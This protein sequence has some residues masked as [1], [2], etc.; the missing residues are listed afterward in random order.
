[1]ILKTSNVVTVL[2]RL[3]LTRLLFLGK[4]YDF[5]LVPFF[6]HYCLPSSKEWLFKTSDCRGY[7][8]RYQSVCSSQV[9]QCFF[10]CLSADGSVLLDFPDLLRF[11]PVCSSKN[12]EIITLAL[13]ICLAVPLNSFFIL[14]YG[15]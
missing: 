11:G 3:I 8:E 12:T 7:G 15:A 5:S 10:C 1:M 4:R 14:Y 6:F 9:L 2:R 13:V